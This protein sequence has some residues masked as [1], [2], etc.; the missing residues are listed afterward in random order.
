M[1]NLS[2][3]RSLGTL[4]CVW[5]TRGTTNMITVFSLS[6][7][8]LCACFLLRH[9]GALLPNQSSID[10]IYIKTPIKSEVQFVKIKVVK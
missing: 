7:A 5:M 8:G 1:T 3:A 10:K 4:F 2:F 9:A 6:S